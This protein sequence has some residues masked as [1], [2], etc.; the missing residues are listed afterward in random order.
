MD[1][2][3]PKIHHNKKTNKGG[4]SDMRLDMHDQA[5]LKPPHE[6]SLGATSLEAILPHNTEQNINMTIIA[7]N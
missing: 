2:P 4:Q 5:F 3:P 6:T 1:A 7:P